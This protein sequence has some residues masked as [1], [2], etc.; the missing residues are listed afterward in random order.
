MVMK[1]SRK[2]PGFLTFSYFKKMHLQQLI[3]MENSNPGKKRG[4]YFS[5]EGTFSIKNSTWQGMKLDLGAE[6]PK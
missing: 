1:K 4:Y 5:V 6:P 3:G 2:F